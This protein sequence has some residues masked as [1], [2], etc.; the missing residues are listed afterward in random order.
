MNIDQKWMEIAINEARKAETEG[1]VP[2]GAI[3][4]KNEKIIAQSHNQPILSHDA[5]AHAEIQ[6]IRE[7]GKLLK[8]YRMKGTTL[9]VTLEPCVMCLG[10][11]MHARIEKLIFGARDY[12]NGVCGSNTDLKDA[13]FFNHNLIIRGGILEKECRLLLKDFFLSLR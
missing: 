9:Y 7:A 5:T 13:Q 6:V 8:N 10:A 11:I 1:E 4:V 12:S 2:I 3:I